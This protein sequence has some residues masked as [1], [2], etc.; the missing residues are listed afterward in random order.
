MKRL[1]ILF[2]ICFM[3]AIP[4]TILGN[5]FFDISFKHIHCALLFFYGGEIYF[6]FTT[7]IKPNNALDLTCRK[8]P[9]RKSALQLYLKKALKA[10][11]R[12]KIMEKFLSKEEIK[13]MREEL[14]SENN[15]P[16]IYPP[17]GREYWDVRRIVATLEHFQKLLTLTVLEK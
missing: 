3:C 15:M 13:K 1:V 10:L 5:I 14:D 7:R 9:A 16:N 8:S 17:K 11:I 12:K 6:Y 4:G 2:I